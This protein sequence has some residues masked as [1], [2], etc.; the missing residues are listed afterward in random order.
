MIWTSTLQIQKH[1]YYGDLDFIVLFVDI[2]A[3][4]VIYLDVVSFFTHVY[5]FI[6]YDVF[7]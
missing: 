2:L 1:V 6:V 4:Y 7:Y 5:S 3:L